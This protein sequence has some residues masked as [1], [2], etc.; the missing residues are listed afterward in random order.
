[1][2][3]NMIQSDRVRLVNTINKLQA[4]PVVYWMSRDQR[5][6]DNWALL[7]AA[8]LAKQRKENLIVVFCLR[9]FFAYAAERTV[10]FMLAGL[11]EVEQD[12]KKHNIPFVFLL[13]NPVTEIP[14]YIVRQKAS[15]LVSD[16]S[17][18][19]HNRVWQQGII[20]QI[21]IPYYEVDAHNIIPC[22]VA[23][24]KQEFGAYTFRPKVKR[25]LSEFLVEF[26]KL[27]TFKPGQKLPVSTPP[28]RWN[29]VASKIAMDHSVKGDALAIPGA[30]AAHRRLAHFI[31]RGLEKYD[32][33]RN[34]PVFDAQSHFSPYLH[35]GQL[36]A[37]R[38]ALAVKGA[39]VSNV[40]V[41]SFLEELIVRREL[42]DNYCYYNQQY[43]TFDGFPAWAKKTLV[44]HMDDI[45]ETQYTREQLEYAKTHDDLWNA[46][47]RE[48]LATGKMHGYMRMYWAKKI[49]EWSKTPALAQ[50]YAIY[51]ND[52]Y[53][54][55]GR[56]PNGYTGI[57]WSIGGL[58]D[59]AWGER[60]IFG[61][62]RYMSY[63]GA[64]SKFS[65]KEYIK[66]WL[67]S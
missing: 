14:K 49:L 22:W 4:G 26:P 66:R 11:A 41:D 34:N 42:S 3:P 40:H 24:P 54:L 45:R 47:Q 62:I 36:S 32:D 1:M 6:R 31:R 39:D 48:L 53:S 13:G 23:S 63:N 20:N 33:L 43:D 61:K 30:V 65:T 2:I 18:L 21:K 25:L 15:I 67:P 19:R 50:Q 9:K 7:Y 64:K 28:V 59:R 56:D 17:P 37:Q 44:E 52:K 60:S 27:H 10:A 16:F 46:A 8:E 58:H 55:D 5:V 51:L 57:A 12:L 29:A 35:F 38:V